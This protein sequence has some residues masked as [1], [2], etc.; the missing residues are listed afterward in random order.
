VAQ[1]HHRLCGQ[2]FG[3]VTGFDRHIKLLK[4]SPWI[5]CL[6]PTDFGMV[7]TDSVWRMPSVFA[8]RADDAKS[9][10]RATPTVN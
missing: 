2:T 3:G 9:S 4:E 7:L 5:Q 6:N 1:C 10:N 8:P